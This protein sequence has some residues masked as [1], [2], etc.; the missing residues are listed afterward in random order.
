MHIGSQITDLEPFRDAFRLMR[1]LADGAAR[2]GHKLAHLDIGGGLGVPY[3]RRRRGAAASG[4][5]AASSRSSS[6]ISAS[7]I[8]LEP[9]RM[10]VGNA[11]ILVTR[12]IYVQGGRRQDVHRSSMRR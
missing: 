12:V 3:R 6:A 5:Y 8:V 2:D 7:K 9:G 10:I 1:E 11:G 4:E